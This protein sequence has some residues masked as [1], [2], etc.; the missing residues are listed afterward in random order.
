MADFIV[1]VRPF[2]G[3]IRDEKLVGLD[4]FENAVCDGAFVFDV[5]GS[6]GGNAEFLAHFYDAVLDVFEVRLILVDGHHH[7]R[8]VGSV[9]CSPSRRCLDRLYR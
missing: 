1:D 7:E 6:N 8:S 2:A 4:F 3:E 9:V 5:V